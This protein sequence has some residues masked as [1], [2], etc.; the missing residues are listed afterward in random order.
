MDIKKNTEIGKRNYIP[1]SSSIF[2]ASISDCENFRQAAPN[3][4]IEE[5]E[6]KMKAKKYFLKD[7][8]QIFT[9]KLKFIQKKY[10]AKLFTTAEIFFVFT[11]TRVYSTSNVMRLCYI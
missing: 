1:T 5:V 4:R 11:S 10:F 7:I 2:R 8:K 6:N 9:E 3:S